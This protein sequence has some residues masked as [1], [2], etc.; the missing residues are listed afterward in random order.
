MR[1][2]LSIALFESIFV[3]LLK[4]FS[5]LIFRRCQCV[6]QNK[7]KINLLKIKFWNVLVFS[8]KNMEMGKFFYMWKENYIL[9]LLHTFKIKY[10][11]II[12]YIRSF[13]LESF[14]K[15][16]TFPTTANTPP[17]SL[18]KFVSMLLSFLLFTLLMEDQYYIRVHFVLFSF[19]FQI[20]FYSFDRFFARAN[21]ASCLVRINASVFIKSTDL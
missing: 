2:N 21:S 13:W 6:Y 5:F 1:Y 8:S 20:R 16:L 10:K 19:I 14:A 11:K 18:S 4:L 3:Y 9:Q 12:M 15:A 7:L 17:F